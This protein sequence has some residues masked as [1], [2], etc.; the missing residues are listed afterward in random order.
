[1]GPATA[2]LSDGAA[3]GRRHATLGSL[4]CPEA[5]SSV[6]D[7]II[8][9]TKYHVQATLESIDDFQ[10]DEST[11][12]SNFDAKADVTVQGQ[13]ASYT[14]YWG[15]TGYRYCVMSI[16]GGGSSGGGS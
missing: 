3:N 6:Q 16:V 7:T 15:T 11:G 13:T 1:M 10:V 2:R 8:K 4:A 14:S 12:E 5:Q 9:V